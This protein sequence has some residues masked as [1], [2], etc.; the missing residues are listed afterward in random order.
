MNEK[1]LLKGEQKYLALKEEKDG[2]LNEVGVGTL[3]ASSFRGT[4]LLWFSLAEQ[5][6][7]TCIVIVTVTCNKLPMC[8]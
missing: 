5:S 2:G 4:V 3:S 6:V 1:N 8:Q 7:R